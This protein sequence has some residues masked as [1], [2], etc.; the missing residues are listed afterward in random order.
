[1]FL[2]RYV[3]KLVYPLCM[4]LFFV[5]DMCN[6]FIVFLH[7]VQCDS[8]PQDNVPISFVVIVGNFHVVFEQFRHLILT[9]F[10]KKNNVLGMYFH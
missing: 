7:L 5:S 3:L 1:M 10:L 6:V 2:L 4:L 8:L 9:I